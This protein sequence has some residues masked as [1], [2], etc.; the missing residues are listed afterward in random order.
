MAYRWRADIGPIL[1][2]GFVALWFYRGSGPVLLRNSIFVRFFRGGGGGQDALS[3]YLN[4]QM[5]RFYPTAHVFVLVEF[6]LKTHWKRR[7]TD[8]CVFVLQICVS[9]A[10]SMRCTH[11]RFKVCWKSE[12]TRINGRQDHEYSYEMGSVSALTNQ[13]AYLEKLILKCVDSVIGKSN[14]KCFIILHKTILFLTSKFFFA[15]NPVKHI[16]CFL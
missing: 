13:I 3:P 6:A 14:L 1:N 7:Y 8:A 2:A 5:P 9:C 4:P 10:F 16:L 15:I 11:I 12:S